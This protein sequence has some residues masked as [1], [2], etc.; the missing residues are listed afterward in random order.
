MG[1]RIRKRTIGMDSGC[2]WGGMLSA[3]RLEDD[4]LFQEPGRN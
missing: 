1:L 3:Y 2:V 4:T